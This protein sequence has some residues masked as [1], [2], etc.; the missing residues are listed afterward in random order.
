M[1]ARSWQATIQAARRDPG[2]AVLAG[3]HALK[4]ALRFGATV[5]RIGSPDPDALHALLADLAPDIAPDLF[6]DIAHGLAPDT[7][8]EV[9]SDRRAGGGGDNAIGVPV[10]FVDE[11]TW[12]V[13]TGGGLPSPVLAVATRPA[14]RIDEMLAI[15]DGRPVILLERP[16]HF[17]NVGA[18]IRVAAAADAAGVVVIGSADPWHP[19]AIRGAA[20]LQFAL[21]VGRRD[22]LPTGPRT[23]VAVT[24]TGAPLG[25]HAL[26]PGA[27]LAFGTERGGL[28]TGMVERADRLVRVPMRPGVSS[29]NLATSV[30]A[31][32][33]G[34]NLGG[35]DRA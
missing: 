9:T 25:P 2:L 28:S 19:R 27:I 35:P 16:R 23:L 11:S 29:L 7:T 3:V 24:P 32:L 17:G 26:P 1:S 33:H 30:A 20:G 4:H 13:V 15:D 6:P 21:P 8:S 5:L 12:D 18:A 34:A 22:E 14:D 31:L 10:E